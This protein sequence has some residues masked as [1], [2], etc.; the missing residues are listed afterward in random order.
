[1]SGNAGYPVD[2]D[3]TRSCNLLGIEYRPVRDTPVEH[4]ERLIAAHNP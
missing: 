3:N 2:F 1:M 4:A